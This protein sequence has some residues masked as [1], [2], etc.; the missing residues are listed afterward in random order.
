MQ[1]FGRNRNRL[2]NQPR[3]LNF[4][5]FTVLGFGISD[6]LTEII[7][8]KGSSTNDFDRASTMATSS[9]ASLR[10]GANVL[11]EKMEA[12]DIHASETSASASLASTVATN[13]P[14]RIDPRLVSSQEDPYLQDITSWKRESTLDIGGLKLDHIFD[15]LDDFQLPASEDSGAE[16]WHLSL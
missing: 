9:T 6:S 13:E 7:F 11:G 1:F 2:S 14:F 3:S 4:L 5:R 10:L 8:Q 16:H 15:D 12:M